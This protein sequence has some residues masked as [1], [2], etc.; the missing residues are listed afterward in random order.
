[1]RIASR[2][3]ALRLGTQYIYGGPAAVQFWI[4]W[5]AR[6]IVCKLAHAKELEELSR[7]TLV[8]I[9]MF[10]RVFAEDRPSEINVGRGD[11]AYIKMWLPNR[12]ERWGVTAANPQTL[13]GL[14]LGLH[15]E[16]AKL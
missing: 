2:L 12:R 1:M 14:R 15:R 10:E 5:Q 3:G 6:A 13:P 4:A 16:A 7:G 9:E 11:D 8:T